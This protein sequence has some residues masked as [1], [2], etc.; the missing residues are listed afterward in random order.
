MSSS[1][2]IENRVLVTRSSLALGLR[3]ASVAESD[4][5]LVHT[6]LS[7]LGF[8]VGGAR[9]VIEALTDSVGKTGTIMMP[10]YSGEL[11][12]PAEWCAPAVPEEWI[13]TI[14]N[15]MPPYEP[16]LTPTR[17]MGTIPELFRHVPGARRSPH[18]QSSFTA[19]GAAAIDL[20]DQ[21]PL[22]YRFGPASPLGKLHAMGGKILMLGAPPQSCSF[23]YLSQHRVPC[24]QITKSAPVT[25]EG[26]KT[27]IRYR[28]VDYPNYWFNDATRDLIEE[29]VIVES[30]IGNAPCLL[31]GAR[32]AFNAVVAWRERH[33]V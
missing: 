13:E 28:D 12:D 14:R 17:R 2:P 29:G 21:H 9:T 7:R 16:R 24:V 8:V 22:D 33:N 1:S 26:R 19:I 5:V 25:I 32:E 15:E 31:M 23:F 3:K 10:T 6:S 4:A 18:P 27:W 11:S 30:K 20:V